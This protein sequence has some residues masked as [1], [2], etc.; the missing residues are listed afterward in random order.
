MFNLSAIAS[1]VLNSI[2]SAAKESLEEPKTESATI[3]RQRRRD[4][5]TLGNITDNIDDRDESQVKIFI[6]LFSPMNTL[7]WVISCQR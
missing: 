4:N 7:V 2:D 5:T 3:I 6:H 1:N